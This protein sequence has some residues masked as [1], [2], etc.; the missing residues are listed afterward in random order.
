[1]NTPRRQCSSMSSKHLLVALVMILVA[2]L[3]NVSANGA[4]VDMAGAWKLP[5]DATAV[6]T[7]GSKGIGKACVEELAG[8]LGMEV[9]TC[10]RNQEELNTCMSE[11]M[12]KGYNVKGVT[13]DISSTEGRQ[14]FIQ[15][16]ENWL[17]E[18]R[19]DVLV[20][21]VGTK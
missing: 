21:N 20:N 11:W 16:I 17:E 12:E 10:C 1:M 18:R 19:L 15:D 2:T 9:L 4:A 7:G 6:V 8:T 5:A 3:T 13:A 14:A